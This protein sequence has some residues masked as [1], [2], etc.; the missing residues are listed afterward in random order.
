MAMSWVLSKSDRRL[1]DELVDRMNEVRIEIPEARY[2]ELVTD[3]DVVKLRGIFD[4]KKNLV[5]YGDVIEVEEY[6]LDSFTETDL[7]HLTWNGCGLFPDDIIAPAI[8]SWNSSKLP[9][10]GK[11]IDID[12][13]LAADL[14]AH[15]ANA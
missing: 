1:A 9:Y 3:G 10:Y 7:V 12:A 14:D 15:Y 5:G 2:C 11:M 6:V 4:A 8:I 13:V